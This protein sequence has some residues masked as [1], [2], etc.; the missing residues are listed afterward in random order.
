MQA[1]VVFEHGHIVIAVPLDKQVKN[2]IEAATHVCNVRYSDA[3][4]D[5]LNSAIG[6]LIDALAAIGVDFN[7]PRIK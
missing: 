7:N 6:D 2:I 1:N 4:W 3:E 5:M